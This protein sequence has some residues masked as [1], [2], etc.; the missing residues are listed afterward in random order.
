[1]CPITQAFQRQLRRTFSGSPTCGESSPKRST[2][3][4]KRL[5]AVIDVTSV[6]HAKDYYWH[7]SPDTAYA[8]DDDP[9]LRVDAGQTHDDLQELADMLADPEMHEALWHSLDH[10]AELMRFLAFADNPRSAKLRPAEP[11]TPE[12]NSS[13][14]VEGSRLP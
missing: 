8:M 6:A 14:D 11:E 2:R 3:F 9:G 12:S 4:E 1:V 13:V 7:L 10:L 5:G